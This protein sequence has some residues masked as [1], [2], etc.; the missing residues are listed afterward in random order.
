[1]ATAKCTEEHCSAKS[2]Q[3]NDTCKT[4]GWP[5][6]HLVLV[7]DTTG[8]CCYC[9]CSCLA[10][11]TP[12]AVSA[13][14]TKSIQTLTLQEPVLA[15]DPTGASQ[16]RSVAFS[17]GTSAT[18]VQ[19][20]M[21]YVSFKVGADERTVTVTMNHTFLLAD[22][23]K[24]IQA[25]MLSVGT[26]LLLADGTT[27]AVTKLEINSYTGGV[28][29][30][31]TS[32]GKP[33]DLDGHLIDTDGI[34]S[35]D[36]AVQTFY[37]DLV[38]QGLAI[39]PGAYPAVTT[40]GHDQAADAQAAV[41][42]AARPRHDFAQFLATVT[43]PHQVIRQPNAQGGAVTLYGNHSAT[44]ALPPVAVTSGYLTE[45]QADELRIGGLHP[46]TR[47]PQ[48]AGNCVWLMTL[49]HAVFPDIHFVFDASAREANGYAFYLGSTKYVL[50][51]G[52]LV[53]AVPLEWQGLSLILGYL[54]NRFPNQPQPSHGLICKAEADYLAP[55]ALQTVFKPLYPHVIFDAI[56]QVEAT[57][58][59]I[60]TKVDQP[61]AGCHAT[62]L[63]C[64]ITTYRHAIGFDP[65]PACAGGPPAADLR[66]LSASSTDDADVTLTFSAPLDD[67]SA[68]ARDNYFFDPEMDQIHKITN[69]NASNTVVIS[70][71]FAPKT[72][73][74]I[75]ASN[76]KSS[77]GNTLDPNYV[78][79]GF[80]TP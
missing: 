72:A 7:C 14:Q 36:F 15:F 64:R 51:Q 29:N 2:Q 60:P 40:R 21:A 24:L 77:E 70:G 50:V 45:V 17:D 30:I 42:L 1:M 26:G 32:I 19:P 80:Y 43:A 73:Y 9:T 55:A 58:K 74:T 62:D 13:T 79:S 69:G 10:F 3:I 34:L 23:R 71:G 35:G 6:N 68:I 52:G 8:Y 56:N 61:T 37:D 66:L 63:G 47:D 18:S 25:Q 46:V 38:K 4:E 28:W 12:V 11:D 44:L 75:T 78:T 20:E 27:A 76:V 49:F 59:L 54:V 39:A 5:V 57:F 22:T 31:A 65:L 41:T 16:Q 53:R 33:V 67:A 48:R